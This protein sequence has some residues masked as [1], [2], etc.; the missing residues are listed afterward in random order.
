MKTYSAK[1]E[2]VKRE[3]FVVDASQAPLGRLASAIAVKL[4]GK[5]KPMF[6]QH[7]DVGDYVVVTNS[8]QLV[9]TGG[10]EEKKDYYR[11]TKFPGGIKK[12]T[13]REQIELDS[14]K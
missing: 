9:V 5:D 4:T 3:W 8:D 2:D 1:P 13:L 10:K 11:H 6:T 7:I 12:R 14:A